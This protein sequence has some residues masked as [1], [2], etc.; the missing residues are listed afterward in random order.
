MTGSSST[1]ELSALP[2]G[3]VLER[4]AAR[5]PAPGGGSAAALACSLAAALVEMAAGFADAPDAADR[6]SRAAELRAR[7]LELAQ[8]DQLSYEPVLRALGRPADDVER[9][10]QLAA[11]RAAAAAAPLAIA[12]VAADV[13]RRAREAA[14]GAGRHV[15]GDCAT[16]AVLAEAACRAAALLVETNLHGT[17]DP[18]RTEAEQLA[19]A[20]I[21]DSKHAVSKAHK[22]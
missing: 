2:L 19:R 3:E 6:R 7:A 10:G 17:T 22:S 21:V 9:P 15:I 20:A 13:A 4:L 11:A 8:R 12:Q 14:E 5:T 16:A 18:R 1:E